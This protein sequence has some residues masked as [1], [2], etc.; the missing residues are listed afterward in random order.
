MAHAM[1]VFA[2]YYRD[3]K[4]VAEDF[5]DFLVGAAIKDNLTDLARMN[6]YFETEIALK[7][8]PVWETI[9]QRWK[10]AFHQ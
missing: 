9:F 6:H 3:G 7:K 1:G 4:M 8:G 5:T 2:Y 10:H